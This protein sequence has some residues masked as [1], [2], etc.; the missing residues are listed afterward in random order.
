M[1]KF[2]KTIIACSSIK[3]ELE[4]LHAGRKDVHLV[5]NP[6]SWHRLPEKLSEMLQEKIDHV[7]G[8]S[9]AIVLGY[10]L[11]SKAT[12]NLKA[13][14][15]G[16]YIPKVHDCISIYLGGNEIYE[17]LSRKYPGTYFLTKNWIDNK[18]DPLGLINNEYQE[19]VGYD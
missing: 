8:E 3:A 4:K 12:A 13:P 19:R 14:D 15:T 7:A 9:E 18:K 5:F 16:L 6:Q 1:K 10:G 2:K 11:C 17:K